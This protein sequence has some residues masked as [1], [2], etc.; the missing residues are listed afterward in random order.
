MYLIK[1]NHCGQRKCLLSVFKYSLLTH[2][3]RHPL[4]AVFLQVLKGMLDFFF[5]FFPP[6]SSKLKPKKSTAW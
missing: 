6:P 1:K 2:S 4:I 5:L 3:P